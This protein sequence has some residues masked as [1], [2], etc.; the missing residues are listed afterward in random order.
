[1]ALLG[2]I[3]DPILDDDGSWTPCF[4]DPVYGTRFHR[5]LPVYHTEVTLYLGTRSQLD[6]GLVR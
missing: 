5:D 2:S 3:P 4:R 6:K 1:M